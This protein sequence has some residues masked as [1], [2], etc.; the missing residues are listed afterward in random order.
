MIFFHFNKKFNTNNI[1]LCPIT[2]AFAPLKSREVLI[3]QTEKSQLDNF[4]QGV[5]PTALRIMTR[6]VST[7]SKQNSIC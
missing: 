6:I 1:L 7:L 3:K 2:I 4:E 5:A